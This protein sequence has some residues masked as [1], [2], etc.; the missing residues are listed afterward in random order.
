[1]TYLACY[2]GRRIQSTKPLI[3]NAC[4]AEK[5]PYLEC[6]H[7]DVVAT[8]RCIASVFSKVA[9][10]KSPKTCLDD[11]L[12]QS[13][14]T[15]IVL[16][17][18]IL[19]TE[20]D[21]ALFKSMTTATAGRAIISVALVDD[22]DTAMSEFIAAGAADV[23]TRKI[24]SGLRLRGL[25]SQAHRRAQKRTTSWIA[26]KWHPDTAAEE[27]LI[28]VLF[29]DMVLDELQPPYSSSTDVSEERHKYLRIVIGQ[30][31][32]PAHTLTDDELALCASYILAHAFTMPETA[33]LALPLPELQRLVA[34]FRAA[35]QP[36]NPYH[37]FRHVVD[38]L[39]ATFCFLLAARALPPH[40]AASTTFTAAQPPAVSLSALITPLDAVALLV[41]ALGHD[42]GHPG[43]TNAF[44][45]SLASPLA[46]LYS[47]RSVLESFHSAAFNNIL[48]RHWPAMT[49]KPVKDVIVDSIL[50]TDMSRHAEYMSRIIA[51]TPATHT[52]ESRRVLLLSL[53]KCADISN[54]ARRLDISIHWGTVLTD[55][56]RRMTLLET[57]LGLP[58]SMP[59]LASTA[60]TPPPSTS[61]AAVLALAKSQLFFIN[62]FALPLFAAVAAL[63]PE[64]T[65]AADQIRENKAAWERKL[66]DLC[67][68]DPK[69]LHA[70]GR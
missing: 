23:V 38:V 41:T 15:P 22:E 9:A 7:D 56:F 47:D 44:L 18:D 39:Q 48:R 63:A 46:R 68:S 70:N 26:G 24:S 29:N 13:T 43:V 37:N 57:K 8:L 16:F 25:L 67:A 30:W 64:L 60:A 31:D 50:A 42:V 17:I 53:M 33:S 35:Y 32:F 34:I 5:S 58:A 11:I 14:T 55:E 27:R 62:T 2:L 6:E 45:V 40:P 65:Y 59:S 66:E 10:Y 4:D 19:T 21:A 51:L 20:T 61:T 36:N 69:I 12:A 3:L 49:T 54:V 28:D 1:M 52:D